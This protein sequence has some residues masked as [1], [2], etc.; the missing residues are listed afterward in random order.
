MAS[1]P[2]ETSTREADSALTGLRR[3]PRRHG[4]IGSHEHRGT[5]EI[6]DE[7]G[8]ASGNTQTRQREEAVEVF[9][10]PRPVLPAPS[11]TLSSYSCPPHADAGDQVMQDR[12]DA[13]KSDDNEKAKVL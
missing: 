13:E 4:R 5:I 1:A 10:E 3:S 9:R 12:D 6:D 11:S 8:P 2:R 7:V